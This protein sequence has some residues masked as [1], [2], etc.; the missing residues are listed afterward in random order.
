MRV[1]RSRLEFIDELVRGNC[2]DAKQLEIIDLS[3]HYKIF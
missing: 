1:I 2:F 3:L